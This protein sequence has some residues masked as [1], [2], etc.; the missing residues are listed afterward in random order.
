MWPTVYVIDKKGY[1]RRWWQGELRWKGADTDQQ[2]ESL[3]E[4]LIEES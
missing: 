4:D 2:L 1:L 3:I